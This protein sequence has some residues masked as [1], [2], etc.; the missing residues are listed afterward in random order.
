MCVDQFFD[1]PEGQDLDPSDLRIGGLGDVCVVVTAGPCRIGDVATGDDLHGLGVHKQL[2][3]WQDDGAE[4]QRGRGLDQEAVEEIRVGDR[5]PHG[6]NICPPAVGDVVEMGQRHTRSAPVLA[7]QPDD[8]GLRQDERRHR[9][10]QHGGHAVHHVDGHL[11]FLV[12]VEVASGDASRRIDIPWCG[13]G[14]VVHHAREN[15]RQH[16]E[17]YVERQNPPNPR[18]TTWR[19]IGSRQVLF[20][21]S[22]VCA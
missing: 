13:Q 22:R 5:I 10:G 14:A 3:Q 12:D 20:Q 21:L 11:E 7:L 16:Q 17:W 8:S 1:I 9:D 2:L 15:P 19:V 18:P 4:D 6:R